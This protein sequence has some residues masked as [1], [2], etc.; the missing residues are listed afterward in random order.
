[1]DQLDEERQESAKEK[2]IND[3]QNGFIGWLL[4]HIG[5]IG[6]NGRRQLFY[7]TFVNHYFGLS[8]D[9]ISNQNKFGYGVTL[10]MFDK[11]RQQCLSESIATTRYEHENYTH[12]TP[13][14]Y[15]NFPMMNINFIFLQIKKIKVALYFSLF[16]EI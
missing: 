5:S 8:R 7:L 3:N 13:Q 4:L 1:L 15:R 14:I 6:S 12:K 9:G 16:E 2:L 11:M 10:D